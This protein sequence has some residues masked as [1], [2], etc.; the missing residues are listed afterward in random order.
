MYQ[1]LKI[2][3]LKKP[4]SRD[5]FFQILG[6][7]T[8]KIFEFLEDLFQLIYENIFINIFF[9]VCLFYFL[10]WVSFYFRYIFH[11]LSFGLYL[12]TCDYLRLTPD[13]ESEALIKAVKIG[14]LFDLSKYS[15]LDYILISGYLSIFFH[16]LKLF[17]V[18]ISFF[19][20]TETRIKVVQNI[21][22]SKDITNKV[23]RE[24]GLK[25][26]RKQTSWASALKIN[27]L[28]KILVLA[29][30][31]FIIFWAQK[32]LKSFVLQNSEL[33]KGYTKSDI[34]LETTQEQLNL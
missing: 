28:L 15:V 31:C 22:K 13:L 32:L 5:S 11:Y 25:E 8:S 30:Y 16:G 27:S 4:G 21:R 19:K 1:G 14:Y 26:P 20:K 24:L 34:S 17:W 7:L 33:K 12:L 9:C 29:L 2:Y 23:L 6:Y 3:N 18:L 10:Y